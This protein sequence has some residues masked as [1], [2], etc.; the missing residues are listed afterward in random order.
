MP[1]GGGSDIAKKRDRAHAQQV[2]DAPRVD[3]I[4]GPIIE[5]R[6]RLGAG[7]HW[8]QRHIVGGVQLARKPTGRPAHVG[9]VGHQH[10]DGGRIPAFQLFLRGGGGRL[11][12]LG[13]RVSR[14][15]FLGR[16]GRGSGRV[17]A[18]RRRLNRIRDRLGLHRR[19]VR[20][21]GGSRFGIVVE[22]AGQNEC[23]RRDQCEN[24]YHPFEGHLVVGYS[25]R[26]HSASGFGP[27]SRRLPANRGL[28]EL[29]PSAAIAQTPQTTYDHRV[30]LHCIRLFQ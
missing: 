15:G 14:L 25:I 5:S 3:F 10:S 7:V 12:L 6:A 21:R 16:G 26:L 29:R 9:S 18:V 27:L 24:Q 13:R 8:G 20:G 28:A 23:A 2:G 4:T 22:A 17:A 11:G 19:L 1:P 30:V